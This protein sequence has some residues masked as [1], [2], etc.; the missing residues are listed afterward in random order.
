MK[1]APAKPAL[2]GETLDSLTE[3]LRARGEPAFRARQILDWVYES[4]CGPAAEIE[5]PPRS[6]CAPGWRKHSI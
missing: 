4:G 6:R 3:R 2:T 1:Y 5:Q